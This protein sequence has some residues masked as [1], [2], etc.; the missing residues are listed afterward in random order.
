MK[1]LIINILFILPALAFANSGEH[2]EGIPWETIGYQTVNVIILLGIIVY[3]GTK[4]IK[5]FFTNK[6]T[7]FLAAA[8]QSVKIRKAAEEAHDD[9][10]VKLNKLESTADESV[11]RAKADAADLI[12]QMLAEAESLAKKIKI[13]TESAA[14]IEIER[15]KTHLREQLIQ[16]SLMMARK[17][18]EAK[19]S[20]EDH[21]RLQGDFINNIQAVQQ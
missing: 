6:K 1:A 15:A 14:N 21:K 16:E 5:E 3:F 18:L 9:I 7:Q 2:H 13:D 17:Q 12:K 20:N 8:E 10:K 11:E 19:V 4:P